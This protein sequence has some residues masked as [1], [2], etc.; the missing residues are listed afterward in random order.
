MRLILRRQYR[1]ETQTVDPERQSRRGNTMGLRK[2]A[3][4]S[5]RWRFYSANFLPPSSSAPPCEASWAWRHPEKDR[6]FP[7]PVNDDFQASL[8]HNQAIRYV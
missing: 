1:D 4:V 6:A 3:A 2:G 8:D 5:R 7:N